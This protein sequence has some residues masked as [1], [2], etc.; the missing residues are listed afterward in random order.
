MCGLE[1]KEEGDDLPSWSQVHLG[2]KRNRVTILPRI[3]LPINC[4]GQANSTRNRVNKRNIPKTT[5]KWWSLMKL[6]IL[7]PYI[8]NKQTRGELNL[9]NFY[10][11]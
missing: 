9:Q 1:D 11:D 2:S 7:F 3:S 6:L 5:D 10:Q 4:T 8:N